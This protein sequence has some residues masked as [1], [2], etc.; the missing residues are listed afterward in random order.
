MLALI[1]TLI[2]LRALYTSAVLLRVHLQQYD[3]ARLEIDPKLVD[4]DRQVVTGKL[5]FRLFRLL[6]ASMGVVLGVAGLVPLL[7]RSAW[8]GLLLVTFIFA[9]ELALQFVNEYDAWL[10]GVAWPWNR[11]R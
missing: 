11:R 7:A 4:A 5:L 8:Y 10:L 6:T 2:C 3:D 1:F 9:V